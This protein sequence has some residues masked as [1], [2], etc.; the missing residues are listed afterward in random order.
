[1]RMRTSH[2]GRDTAVVIGAGIAGLCAA[3]ALAEHFRSVI[4]LEQDVLS[5]DAQHRKSAPHAHH[6]H[7]MSAT[8]RLTLGKLFPDADRLFAQSAELLDWCRDLRMYHVGG[9]HQ[10]AL[11]SRL[12]VRPVS[13]PLL[14]KVLR[15]NLCLHP[16]LKLMDGHKV[17]GLEC[18]GGTVT[19]ARV[20]AANGELVIPCDLLVDTS[21]SQSRTV[22]WLQELGGHK[23]PY[24]EIVQQDAMYASQ[25]YRAPAGTKSSWRSMYVFCRPPQTFTGGA[26]LPIENGL[27][28]VTLAGYDGHTPPRKRDGFLQFADRLPGDGEFASAL[29]SATAVSDVRRFRLPANRWRRFDRM[30][31]PPAGFLCLGNALCEFD[32]AYGQGMTV[33]AQCALALG[34]LLR[35]GV[36]DQALARQFYRTTTTFIR[37][38]WNIATLSDRRFPGT[39]GKPL[40]RFEQMVSAY[41]DCVFEAAVDDPIMWQRAMAVLQLADSP[42]SWYKFDSVRR[43]IR[44]RIKGTALRK[45]SPVLQQTNKLF[46]ATAENIREV[47]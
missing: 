36:S 40:N 31:R 2:L 8:G 16:A 13:R 6:V 43:I 21:G 23:A 32:P 28:H 34:E 17:L 37:V 30:L 42:L 47:K 20:Q 33:A 9:W 3:K 4:L 22:K 12:L 45:R 27:W 38:P 15:D 46:E 39:R 10:H 5:S 19:G 35:K 1:M 44:H 26:I 7:V 29:R 41:G 25:L 14:E 18:T 11:E 24:E